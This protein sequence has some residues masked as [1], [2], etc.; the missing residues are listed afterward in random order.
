MRQFP[1]NDCPSASELIA[2]ALDDSATERQGLDSRDWSIAQ[3]LTVCHDCNQAVAQ[4][5]AAAEI[6]R[7]QLPRGPDLDRFKDLLAKQRR[8]LELTFQEVKREPR[9]GDI[10]T[11]RDINWSSDSPSRPLISMLVVVLRIFTRPFTNNVVIDVAPVTEDLGLAAEWSLAFAEQHSGV[12]SPIVVH[13]DFQVTTSMEALGRYFGALS[14]AAVKCLLQSLEYYDAAQSPPV[15]LACGSFGKTEVR[16]L[17]DWHE[18]QHEL[19]MLIAKL[20]AAI[21]EADDEGMAEAQVVRA[22]TEP[23]R[24]SLARAPTYKR[25]PSIRERPQ[26]PVAT[27]YQSNVGSPTNHKD[28]SEGVSRVSNCRE[29]QTLG[30]LVD[31]FLN[32]NGYTSAG[33]WATRRHADFRLKD[34]ELVSPVP[35]VMLINA[36]A[37]W[38]PIVLRHIGKRTL[39]PSIWTLLS[40]AI[41]KYRERDCVG[42]QFL[43]TAAR[44]QDL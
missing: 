39:A 41:R 44:S 11:T 28:K 33:E 19:E 36:G 43:A 21:A 8:E 40:E 34:L 5:R 16:R 25:Q 23:P 22:E 1:F 14:S 35:L 30:E 38:R 27:Y 37:N 42:A 6:E 10:W 3:H 32:V 7:A 2:H 12:G 4:A 9:I 13:V 29:A 17:D 15:D 20:A 24:E 26:T 31:C 18:L